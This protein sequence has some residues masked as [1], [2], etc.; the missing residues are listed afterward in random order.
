M[1]TK[2][3]KK[4]RIT[5]AS[6]GVSIDAGAE[7]VSRM[8]GYVRTTFNKNVLGDLGSFGGLFKLNTKGFK[9]PILVSSTDGVGTKIMVAAQAKVYHTV[10][11]DLVN[12]CVNDILVQGATPLFFLDY[13]ATG[14]LEPKVTAEV[15]RGLAIACK[16]QGTVLIGGETAEMPGLYKKGDFDLAGTIVGVVDKPNLITGDS[17]KPGDVILGLRSS[18]LHT[19]GFSLARKVL[20]EHAKLPMHK[21]MAELDGRTLAEA[22]LAPHRCYANLM[23][24][25]F[26]QVKV[27]AI[28]HL[29]GGGFYDN[30]PRVLPKDCKA[31]IHKAGWEVPPLFQ[32]ITRLG[33]VPAKDAFRTLNM[34]I[35]LVFMVRAND[36]PAAIKGLRK[37]GE[38]ALVLG[39]VTKGLRE[40]VLV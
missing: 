13:F 22:L 19:N 11:Q 12:H 2:S 34:G 40:A 21:K 29:T 27:R 16:Q 33:N 1:A 39:R 24:P 30:I 28:S 15:V 35:G 10:G 4:V 20:F 18:G 6:A 23:L 37:M 32:M 31:V 9:D 26:K 3:K 36:V 5:Y 17:V 14:V 7:A 25:L 38:E 8:K